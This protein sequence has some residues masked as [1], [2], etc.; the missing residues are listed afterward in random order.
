MSDDY[1]VLQDATFEDKNMVGIAIKRGPDVKIVYCAWRVYSSIPNIEF[2]NVSYVNFDRRWTK[3]DTSGHVSF[4]DF[5]RGTVT[6][7]HA[8]P[9]QLGLRV[10][11]HDDREPRI[12][13]VWFMRD[14][15]L[16]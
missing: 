5:G 15:R 12:H 10:E 3:W 4:D 2:G 8:G 11:Y 7:E 1:E 14:G 13:Q 6:V 16:R 9:V